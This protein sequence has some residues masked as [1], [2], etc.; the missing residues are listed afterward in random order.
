MIKA[1]H[2]A[3]IKPQGDDS[4]WMPH[5]GG[6]LWVPRHMVH[7]FPTI[8]SIMD[9]WGAHGSHVHYVGKAFD[10]VME[11]F[12]KKPKPKPPHLPAPG[13]YRMPRI[14][15]SVTSREEYAY[16]LATAPLKLGGK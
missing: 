16:H 9:T 14:K 4:L 13:E 11:S 8:G 3:I 15:E 2:A 7:E 6:L 12:D 10:L 5:L 1:T